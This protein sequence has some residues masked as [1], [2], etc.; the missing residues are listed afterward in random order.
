MIAIATPD[1]R[2]LS[3]LV[4]HR[5]EWGCDICYAKP[6]PVN[7]RDYITHALYDNQANLHAIKHYCPLCSPPTTSS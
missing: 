3:D 1:V 6:T 2:T 7:I 5:F 4:R